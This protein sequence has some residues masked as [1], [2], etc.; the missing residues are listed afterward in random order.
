MPKTIASHPSRE[1]LTFG[2]VWRF[3]TLPFCPAHLKTDLAIKRIEDLPLDDLIA[4]GVEGVLLDA[5]GTLGMH[6]C[7]VYPDAVVEKVR[8]MREKG[9]K[10]AIYTNSSEDRFQQFNPVE[11]VREAAP[12][13]DPKGFEAAMKNHLHLS[14]PAK[15][16][17]VG[18]NYVTDAGAL[19]AGMRFIY[20]KPIEGNEGF[21]HSFTRYLAYLCARVHSR[22]SFRNWNS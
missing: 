15:V 21:F 22:E 14:D 7:R 13:P 1:G 17:M 3:L 12:K 16:C 9:L 4:D 20:V 19:S 6:H 18:D 10:V 5:D 11:I 2:K 8:Q